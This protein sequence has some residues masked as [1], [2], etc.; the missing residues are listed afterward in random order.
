MKS[1]L[2]QKTLFDVAALVFERAAFAVVD[3]PPGPPAGA[4]G[5]DIVTVVTGFDGPL[6]GRVAISA[7]EA[8]ARLLAASMLGEDDNDPDAARHARDALGELCNMV[9]GNLLP[10][11]TGHAAEFRIDPP[12]LVDDG[13]LN[14]IAGEYAPSLTWQTCLQVEDSD[15]RVAFMLHAEAKE[16]EAHD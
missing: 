2:Y 8:L 4:P 3:V 11:L 10:R 5:E 1:H 7:P 14:R 9:C 6:S 13:C 15:V 12:I 16:A